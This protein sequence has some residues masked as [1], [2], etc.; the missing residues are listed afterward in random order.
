MRKVA[1]LSLLTL[2]YSAGA[3]AQAVAGLGAISGTVRDA[4]GAV[5]PDATV[6]VA[7]ES[8]GIRRTM[9]TTDAGVFAAPALVPA[10]NYSLTVTRQGFA[11]W[12]AKDFEV[13]VGQT[14]DFRINLQ[15]TTAT[16]KIEVTAEAPLVE[17]TKSGVS[18]VVTQQQ[19][20]QLPI[21][22]RRADTFVLLTP[23]VTPDGTFGLVS[24]RGISSGNS[25]L[26]DGN[27]T[28]NSFYNENAGRTRISTQ[29]S[30]DAVQ[31]FQ[32]LSD[33]FSAEF[34]RALGGPPG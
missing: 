5:V 1:A 9:Q 3:F 8:K 20:D 25:F 7:N 27:D 24:F 17:D 11:T 32:V 31:E 10:S 13:L 15:V 22:G 19:I 21:N 23:A 33:G 26:T 2:V 30:Q 14:V 16:T 28:T 6:V 18:Q 34:G 4:S 29:I 12:E